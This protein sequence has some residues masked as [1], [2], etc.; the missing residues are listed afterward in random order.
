MACHYIFNNNQVIPIKS[1]ICV[2][3]LLDQTK[4]EMFSHNAQSHVYFT[5]NTKNQAVAMTSVC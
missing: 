3:L 4:M 1:E 5:T 2:S